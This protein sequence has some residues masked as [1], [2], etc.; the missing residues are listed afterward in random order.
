MVL[1]YKIE[2]VYS[3]EGFQLGDLPVKEENFKLNSV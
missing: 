1:I 3:G 2:L